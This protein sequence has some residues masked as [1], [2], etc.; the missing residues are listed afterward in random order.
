MCE[1]HRARPSSLPDYPSLNH[2]TGAKWVKPLTQN[3]LNT[4][5]GGHF[6]DV[7]LSSMLFTHRVDD[8]HRV[9]LEV[10]SAPGLSKPL[11]QEAMKQNFKPAKKGDS[12]GPSCKLS[13][14][15]WCLRC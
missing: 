1:H 2:G 4:F 8:S 12:F 9:K 10:W 3:R 11:F 6:S 5:V 13:P 15:C 7:N 14:A